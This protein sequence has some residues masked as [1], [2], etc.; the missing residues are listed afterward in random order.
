[1][2]K[3]RNDHAHISNP[4]L[5]KNG[6]KSHNLTLLKL[7]GTNTAK[8]IQCQRVKFDKT[9]LEHSSIEESSASIIVY[10]STFKNNVLGIFEPPYPNRLA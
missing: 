1:M 5:C 4:I 2:Y 9:L 6:Q 3:S 10:G 7:T 8:L